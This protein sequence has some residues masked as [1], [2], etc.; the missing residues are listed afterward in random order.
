M[1]ANFEYVFNLF[2]QRHDLAFVYLYMTSYW[3]LVIQI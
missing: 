2:V 1:L 3:C